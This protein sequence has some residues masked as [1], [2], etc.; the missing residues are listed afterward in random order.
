ML[1]CNGRDFPLIQI[2]VPVWTRI[3]TTFVCCFAVPN[4]HRIIGHKSFKVRFFVSSLSRAY[5]HATIVISLAV[6][7]SYCICFWHVVFSMHSQISFATVFTVLNIYPDNW[8]KK[9]NFLL[10]YFRRFFNIPELHGLPHRCNHF[11][12]WI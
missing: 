10:K 1:L 11:S 12:K 2:V 5:H 8:I 3:W 6:L 9:K 7:L 4:G